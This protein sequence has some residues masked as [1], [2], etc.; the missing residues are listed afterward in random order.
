MLSLVDRLKTTL[1]HIFNTFPFLFTLKS[2]LPSADLTE[3]HIYLT[4]LVSYE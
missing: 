2:H 3:K 4:I 1:K